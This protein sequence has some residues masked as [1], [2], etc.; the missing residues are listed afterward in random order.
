MARK[1]PA[2]KS[3]GKTSN[4]IIIDDKVIITRKG[5]KVKSFSPSGERAREKVIPFPSKN[6]ENLHSSE[7]GEWS[8]LWESVNGVV[9]ILSDLSPAKRWLIFWAAV[10]ILTLLGL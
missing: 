7:N 5:E 3:A 9:V 8:R 6:P 10:F 1:K 2:E 4:L